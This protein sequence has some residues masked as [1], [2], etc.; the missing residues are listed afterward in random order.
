[1]KNHY[2]AHQ[3]SVW[4]RLIPE[5]HRAG[6]EDVVPRHNLFRNH[7]DVKLYDGIV[8]PNPLNKLND[9]RR[10]GGSYN[11]NGTVAEVLLPITTME[12]MV[13]TCVSVQI[14]RQDTRHHSKNAT[15]TVTANME[16]AGYAAYTTAFNV[17]IAIGCS[18]LILNILIFAGVYYQ[19][20]KTKL[21][22]KTLQQQRSINNFDSIGKFHHHPSS[23]SVILDIEREASTIIFADGT[24]PRNPSPNHHH[25]SLTRLHLVKPTM[26]ANVHP[27]RNATLPRNT[28][29]TFLNN[30]EK[31]SPPNGSTTTPTP[32]ATKT[33]PPQTGSKN[34]QENQP[35]ISS[36]HVQ[37]ATSPASTLQTA[38]KQASSL[39]VPAAAMSE[40]RV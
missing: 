3:L 25:N 18:L 40:M 10:R 22:I 38:S 24:L 6:M 14:V 34:T 5:L 27:N 19:R 26:A 33:P 32:A 23:A 15:D 11:V 8:R 39:K 17:T 36:N 7:E 28:T 9:T 16:A 31:K 21:E 2:R 29:T 1:M 20:D 30:I 37:N 12:T 13:T 4:L 35:M